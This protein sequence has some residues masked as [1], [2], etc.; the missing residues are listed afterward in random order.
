VVFDLQVP[1]DP[2]R[3]PS[4]RAA[5]WPGDLRITGVCLNPTRT[6]F[7]RVLERMGAK[8]HSDAVESRYGEPVGDLIAAPSALRATEVG[9]TEIPGLIDEIPMLAALAT[10][11]EGA[12]GSGRLGNCG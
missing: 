1:G 10:R 5:C 2:S 8:V 4:R 11:A 7:L 12:T 9:A 3:P 6:G